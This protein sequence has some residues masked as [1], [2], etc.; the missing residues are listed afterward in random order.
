MKYIKIL[1]D[2][3]L[4]LIS[5]ILLKKGEVLK[6][7]IILHNNNYYYH[8]NNNNNNILPL[9]LELIKEITKEEYSQEFYIKNIKI[10]RDMISELLKILEE[11]HDNSKEQK[12]IY[13]EIEL[14]GCKLDD[15]IRIKNNY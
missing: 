6:V 8:L 5:S 9:N 7:D 10:G 1:E 11:H 3:R 15:I 4:G 2:I 12:S 14:L 13:K